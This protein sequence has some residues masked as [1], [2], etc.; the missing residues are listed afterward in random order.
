VLRDRVAK[1]ID[2]LDP[3]DR[4][5]IRAKLAALAGNPRP[6]GVVLLKGSEGEY[7]LRVGAYRIIYTIRDQELLVLILR[8]GHRREVFG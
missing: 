1:D 6:P 2:H 8:V 5:R 3:E 4:Q 7:R